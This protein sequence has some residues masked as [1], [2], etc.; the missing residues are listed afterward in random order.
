MIENELADAPGV[1][2]EPQASFLMILPPGWVRLPV[3]DEHADELQVLIEGIV[4]E[5][6][7]SSLPRDSTEPWRGELRKRFRGVVR[8]AQQ[9][10][11]TAVYFP[12]Q[13]VNGLVVPASLIES[14]IEDDGL[15]SADVFLESLMQDADSSATQETVD[16]APAVRTVSARTRLQVDGD[17]P[18][19][20]NRQVV[21]TI[22]VP[23]REGR[24]IVMSFSAVSSDSVSAL[25]SDALVLL[26]DALMTTFR[27]T[28]VPGSDYSALELRLQNINSHGY[29]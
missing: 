5:A 28:D 2:A 29:E 12:T 26:F 23:H 3:R 8:E 17:W 19:V 6:L 18:E 21:Y 13:A 15:E 9:A 4:A 20:T 1:G 22:R 7:P 25:L 14:E 27:W 11:A 10:G 24:W 16:G